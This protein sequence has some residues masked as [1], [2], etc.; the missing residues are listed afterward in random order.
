[1]HILKTQLLNSIAFYIAH[2]VLF[3]MQIFLN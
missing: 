2:T 3:I 1:M